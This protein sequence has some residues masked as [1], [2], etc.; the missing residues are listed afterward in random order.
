MSVII[1]PAI[2]V[3][4]FFKAMIKLVDVIMGSRDGNENQALDIIVFFSYLLAGIILSFAPAIRW[5]TALTLL[6]FYCAAF[7]LSNRGFPSV[8]VST[9]IFPRFIRRL[10]ILKNPICPEVPDME[11]LFHLRPG[12]KL[13]HCDIAFNGR[14]VSYGNYDTETYKWGRTFGQ[15]IFFTAERNRYIRFCAVHDLKTTVCYG[16]KLSPERIAKA[17]EEIIRILKQSYPWESKFQRLCEREPDAAYSDD[18]DYCSKLWFAAGAKFRKFHSGGFKSY[19]AISKNCV[20]LVWHILR[21]TGNK[22]HGMGVI[23][24]PGNLLCL[25]ERL[26]KSGDDIVFSRIVYNKSNTIKYKT[27]EED[28]W[29]KES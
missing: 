10:D 28:V 29:G 17:K 21:E 26:F 27:D 22:I 25:L 14:V 13:G 3:Y 4:I 2:I 16:L 6:I 20:L 19:F 24:T 9:L 1:I 18:L 23:I 7:R 5:G 8:F 15:G 12:G 11:V